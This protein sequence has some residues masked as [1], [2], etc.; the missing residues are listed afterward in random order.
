MNKRKY[1]L[2]G[3]GVG[4]IFEVL[5]FLVF[6]VI[7]G[8]RESV[9]DSVPAVTF[10]L[11]LVI[12]M[13][14]PTIWGLNTLNRIYDGRKNGSLRKRVSQRWA[15]NAGFL[16]VVLFSILMMGL[17][18][19]DYHNRSM[20]NTGNLISVGLCFAVLVYASVMYIKNYFFLKPRH[21]RIKDLN[22]TSSLNGERRYTFL[23][24]EV[25]DENEYKG[26]VNG[27]M[28]VGDFVHLIDIKGEPSLAKIRKIYS[29]ENTEDVKDASD[30][31]AH[32]ILDVEGDSNALGK[33]GVISSFKPCAIKERIIHA[34]NPRLLA[35]IKNYNEYVG[36]NDYTSALVYDACHSNYIV[37]AMVPR[38]EDHRGEIMDVM[39]PNQEYSF[40]SVVANE[41]KEDEAIMPIFTDWDALKEYKEVIDSESAV[42]VLLSFPEIVYYMRKHRYSG[43]ALNPFGPKPFYFSQEYVNHITSLEGYKEDFIYNTHNED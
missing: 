22:R 1:L 12:L 4:F 27:E 8:Y 28:K 14:Y 34:E 3:I 21:D 29:I 33:Y 15:M 2:S 39:E 25:V 10:I 30:D 19:Y 43:L 7:I 16:G 40:L 11:A 17:I 13:F 6:L 32:I 20:R 31:K 36:D 9:M 37:P 18:I 42:S 5:V 26:F 38:K 24:D 41:M 23:V 35:M